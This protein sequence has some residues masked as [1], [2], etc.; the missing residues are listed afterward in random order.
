M[1]RSTSRKR[2]SPIDLT[3]S[4][5]PSLDIID[6][7]RYGLRRSGGDFVVLAIPFVRLFEAFPVF[8]RHKKTAAIAA[9]I[10]RRIVRALI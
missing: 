1:I 6:V 4:Q 9:P 8:A 2:L 10:R 5:A 3:A 7:A